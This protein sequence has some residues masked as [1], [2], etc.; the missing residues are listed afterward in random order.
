[1]YKVTIWDMR[2]IDSPEPAS[3]FGTFDTYEIAN[4]E[5]NSYLRMFADWPESYSPDGTFAIYA[6]QITKE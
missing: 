6:V 5:L 2:D 4:R 1:M 3:D